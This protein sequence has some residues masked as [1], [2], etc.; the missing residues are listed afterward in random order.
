M[1]RAVNVLIFAISMLL[2]GCNTQKMICPAYQSAFI[3][4][5]PSQK[6]AFVYYNANKSQAREVLASNSKILTLPAN[7]STWNRS[8]VLPGPALPKER[9]TKKTRYLLLPQKTYKKA[10]RAL[11]T[12]EMKR[13]YPK[14]PTDF[15]DIKKAL[16]SAARS[17]TDTLS[18]S[19]VSGGDKQKEQEEQDST[20]VIS[21]E[22]E[23]FNVDQDNYMWYL[24]K[25]L[26]LPDVRIT[27]EGARD[28]SVASK[29]P[30]KK[31]G[32][33]KNLFKKKDKKEKVLAK[34]SAE[35]ADQPADS[36]GAVA[37]SPQ[38]IKK[39]KG[40]FGF[41]KKKSADVVPPKKAEPKKEE[42]EK[43]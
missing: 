18:A 10:L 8:V 20:Y 36:T 2:F 34:D 26:V 43:F 41:L 4:D 17:I 27:L 13:V 30:E 5:K 1:S 25:I 29:K 28:K 37:D 12:I 6:E 14:K 24:R 38:P 31:G 40:V 21:I 11:Q 32:F 42:E 15:V 35:L 3:Y 7:D 33:F 23:K 16:D 22:K 39:K 9:K 19:A